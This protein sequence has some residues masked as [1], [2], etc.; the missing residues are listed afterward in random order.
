MKRF[1]TAVVVC[2]MSFYLAAVLTAG[3]AAAGEKETTFHCWK[4]KA[5]FKM[6]ASTMSGQCPHCG[7]KF[8]RKIPTP[9]PKPEPAVISWEDGANYVGKTKTVEGTV[10]GTHLSSGSGNLY[11]NFNKDYRNYLSV[12]IP[13]SDLRRFRGDAAS[14]YQN[15]KISAKGLIQRQK[16]FLRITVKNPEDLK[17][18]E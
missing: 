5:S 7:A 9:T 2:C 15:K 14:Y 11:L 12:Q 10:A 18:L 8:A 4:C 1:F 6:P 13:A 16:G 3:G 17:V